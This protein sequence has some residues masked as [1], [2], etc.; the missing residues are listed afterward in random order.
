MRRRLLAKVLFTDRQTYWPTLT[1]CYGNRFSWSTAVKTV[2][3]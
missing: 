1:D 2:V 3:F